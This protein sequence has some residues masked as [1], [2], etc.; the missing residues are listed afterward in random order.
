MHTALI[1]QDQST[2]VSC[3]YHTQYV[4]LMVMTHDGPQP[5]AAIRITYT[6]WAF[7]AWTASVI[8]F[9]CH[10]NIAVPYAVMAINP[11]VSQGASSLQ[12]VLRDLCKQVRLVRKLSGS[13]S[14][15]RKLVR[16]LITSAFAF[17]AAELTTKLTLQ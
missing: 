7:Y 10:V 11:Y 2:D 5:N 17:K 15:S 3:T 1:I 8:S 6:S 14:G 13:G 4:H 9:S 16:N 12:S